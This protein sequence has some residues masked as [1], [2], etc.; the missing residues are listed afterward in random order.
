MI[1]RIVAAMV[2][3]SAVMLAGWGGQAAQAHREATPLRTVIGWFRAINAKNASKT[4]S[5]LAPA[6]R[7]QWGNWP[8]STWSTFTHLHCKA[9]DTTRKMASVKCTFHE[10]YSPSEGNPDTWW[11]IDLRRPRRRWLIESWGQA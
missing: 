6:A 9:L 11:R 5:Y 2:V 1:R 10:S 3:G 7:A 8:T 4:R